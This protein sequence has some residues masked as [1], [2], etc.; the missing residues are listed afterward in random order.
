[1]RGATRHA[2]FMFSMGPDGLLALVVELG[3]ELRR[4]GMAEQ[5]RQLRIYY[6]AL[7]HR[8]DAR[9][10]VEIYWDEDAV[11]EWCRVLRLPPHQDAYPVQ[12]SNRCARCVGKPDTVFTQRIFP[13]GAKFECRTCGSVWLCLHDR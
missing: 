8:L 3:R 1:L 5:L 13:G 7:K 6:L 4:R 2:D 12:R 9:G 10:K 11:V